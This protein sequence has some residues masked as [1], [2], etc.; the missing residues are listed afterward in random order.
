MLFFANG[1]LYTNWVPRIPAVRDALVLDVRTLGLTLLGMGLGALPG[2]LLAGRLVTRFGS[3]P[4]ALGSATAL[5][6]ALPLLGV[7]PSAVA[8]AAV[9]VAIGVADAVMDVSMNA[10]GVLVQR[11]E[12]RSILNGLHGFWSLGAVGGG[13]SGSAAAALGIPVAAHLAL[14]AALLV[15]A[16]LIAA[17]GLLRAVADRGAVTSLPA[18]PGAR[19]AARRPLAILGL[20]TLLA[21]LIEDTPASWS[22]VYLVDEFGAGAGVAGLAFTAFAAAM[23]AGRFVADRATERFGAVAVTR[24]GALL[25]ASGFTISLLLDQLIAGVVGFGLVGLGVAPLFPLAFSAAGHLPG[26]PAGAGI[27][28][29]SLIARVGFL[30]APP[31]VG[32]LAGAVGLSNALL[33]VVAAAVAIV[34]VAAGV[35]PARADA[36]PTTVH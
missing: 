36:L 32:V 29:V 15:G 25:A 27:A 4:V 21:A 8:L 23:T 26:V 33:L 22:A 18:P 19:P 17:R 30:L 2:S 5:G 9:L 16:V 34:A 10:H 14:I 12:G 31:A 24:A 7:A 35:R 6:A 1:A 11:L 13:L 3:R 28:V 20:L